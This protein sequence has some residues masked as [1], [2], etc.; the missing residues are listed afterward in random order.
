M[1]INN[2]LHIDYVKKI[3]KEMIQHN[4]RVEIND[5]EYFRIFKHFVLGLDD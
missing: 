4:L 5:K 1:P 3:Q 2:M